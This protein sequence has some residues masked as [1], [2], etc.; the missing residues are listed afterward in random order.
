MKI[1]LTLSMLFILASCSSNN[2]LEAYHPVKDKLKRQLA[3]GKNSPDALMCPHEGELAFQR[4]YEIIGN[5]KKYAHITVYSWSDGGLEKAID[6]AL[7]QK[8]KVR[9]ILHPDLKDSKKVLDIVPVLESKGAEFKFAAMNMHEKFIVVDDE[10]V[11]NTSANF[12][13]GAKNKYSENVVY[14]ELAKENTEEIKGLIADFKNEFTILWNT[15]KDI[16]S[17]GEPIAEK[18]N[19]YTK[20]ENVPSKSKMALYSS[21]MNWTLKE[22][23]IGS[24]GQKIG[25]YFSLV[26]KTYPNKA[27]QTWTVRD[28][29]IEKINSAQKS[30]YLSLNHFNIRAV[31]DALVAAVKRGV[32]VRLAVDNQEYKGKPNDLEMTPQFVQDW[33]LLKGKKVSPPVRVKYYSHE[34]SPRS[35]LLNH[36]KFVIVDFEVPGK[37]IL[38]SGSYNLSATAEQNQF[39]NL[40][41]YQSEDYRDLY[42]TFKKEF[43]NQWFWNRPNDKPKQDVIDLFLTAKGGSYPIH[44][45][46]AVSLSWEEVQNLRSEVNKKAPG[47]YSGL[48]KNRDCLYYDPGKKAYWACPDGK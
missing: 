16:I 17:K 10:S 12:S 24:A 25:K 37:T 4:M 20:K 42:E 29:L 35:W 2:V 15:G 5:A 41:V 3:S 44:I 38:L 30:I 9:V 40:V 27:E 32:D 21:S 18:L 36:H 13:G 11:S 28:V 8:A 33:F 23:K 22:N 47:I 26:K 7:S 19:D 46:D 6:K 45:Q 39:D 31:S 1:S 48:T 14:H 43:D 34:P